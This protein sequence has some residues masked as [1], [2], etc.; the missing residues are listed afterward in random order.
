MHSLLRLLPVAALTLGS[1][2][3][4]AP[5]PMMGPGVS[6]ELATAR[7]RDLGSI[8]YQLSLSVVARDTARGAVTIRF[9]AKRS[10][11]VVVDFR[12]PSLTNVRVNAAAAATT[13]NGAHLRFRASAGRV[14][15]NVVTA[16]FKSMIAPAGASII[17]F[18]DDRDG[19]DYLY[20]LLVPSDA[21]ALFPCFDQPDLKARLTLQL[22]VPKGWQA[23][24]NGITE[25]IDST[26]TERTFHF[27]ESDPLPTYL[28]AFAAGPWVTAK[29]GPR[30]TSLWVRPS[31]FREV[32]VDSLQNQVGSALTS[33]EKYFGVQYPFQQFQYMLSPA[34]PSGL[35]A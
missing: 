29:G 23:L 31:R 18:H 35:K 14:G 1:A 30:N 9:N 4:A 11:D 8:R 19:N 16:D 13:F 7:A 6:K 22:T 3:T 12:G 26:T 24:G 15:D 32:E 17:R 10:T 2:S 27:R 34:F 20:T 28:F 25:R 33:L 5:D 21:N